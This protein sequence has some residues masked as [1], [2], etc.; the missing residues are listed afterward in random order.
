MQADEERIPV[1][2]GL[3]MRGGWGYFK[4]VTLDKMRTVFEE[5]RDR[6]EWR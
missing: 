2:G 4:R 5:L 6:S 1:S 3:I